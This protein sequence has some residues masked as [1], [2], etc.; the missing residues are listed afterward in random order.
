[1][2]QISTCRADRGPEAGSWFCSIRFSSGNPTWRQSCCSRGSPDTT[3]SLP[4]KEGLSV[5]PDALNGV[6][7]VRNALDSP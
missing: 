7:G 6:T 2:T 4:A 3:P 1:M 5:C